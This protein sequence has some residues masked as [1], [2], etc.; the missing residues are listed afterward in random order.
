MNDD[1]KHEKLKELAKNDE[2]AKLLVDGIKASKFTIR[3]AWEL[4]NTAERSD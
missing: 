1:K 3:Q 4:Y 2:F